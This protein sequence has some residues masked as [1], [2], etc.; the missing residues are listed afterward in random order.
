MPY[1]TVSYAGLMD[2]LERNETVRP[3]EI[4]DIVRRDYAIANCAY[5]DVSLSPTA[6]RI[7][8]LCHTFPKAWADTYLARGFHRIDPVLREAAR[9][10]VP[11]DWAAAGMRSDKPSARAF[12]REARRHG[13]GANGVALPLV[14]RTKRSVIFTCEARL[15]GRDWPAYRRRVLG[16]LHVMASLFHAAIQKTAP[17]VAPSVEGPCGHDGPA[18]LTAREIEVVKWVAAGKSYWEI[19]IIL[20]ISE[21]TVRHFMTNVRAKLDAVSNSQAIARAIAHRLIMLG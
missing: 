10:V 11:V 8:R 14:S 1:E 17:P 15:P 4:F 19:A 3:A 9:S 2:R 5:V 18:R 16:E 12:L 20:G 13:I 6:L 7:H 21:R